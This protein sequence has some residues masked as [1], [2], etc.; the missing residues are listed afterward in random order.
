MTSEARS[1]G[2]RPP[3][4]IRKGLVGRH[5][6]LFLYLL[7]TL[8]SGFVVIV[9]TVAS[10]A[11]R[12]MPNLADPS[13]TLLILVTAVYSYFIVSVILLVW[14]WKIR[15]A[16]KVV[17]VKGT[18]VLRETSGLYLLVFLL[19]VAISQNLVP[20]D[21][22]NGVAQIALGATMFFAVLVWTQ[23]V[24]PG[25]TSYLEAREAMVEGSVLSG[26]SGWARQYGRNVLTWLLL[27]F[28]QI[29]NV[30][31]LLVGYV[32]ANHG[33]EKPREFW[34]VWMF[35]VINV[36]LMI[37]ALRLWP[38]AGIVWAKGTQAT[39]QIATANLALIV[40]N[41]LQLIV[42][43][44][45]SLAYE[46]VIAAVTGFLFLGAVGVLFGPGR[47]AHIEARKAVSI[48]RNLPTYPVGSIGATRP[49]K[50]HQYI[51]TAAFL[52]LAASVA[53]AAK[54]APPIFGSGSGP[55]KSRA[56]RINH[57]H[58]P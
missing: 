50:R 18:E 25:W 47:S 40:F 48:A 1:T 27:M 38:A 46:E 44:G 30:F 11:G 42:F 29:E 24:G 3:K 28:A 33:L 54:V 17:W 51:V 56:N 32:F 15:K 9:L 53:I 58:S 34:P 55:L 26:H 22:A 49:T 21:W 20:P 39:R 13:S 43:Q 35:L 8:A 37:R 57:P 10:L 36:Y 14:A 19:Y 31:I 6:L 52:V 41:F 12:G 45:Q 16:E 4:I 23:A 5:F 7:P 2:A